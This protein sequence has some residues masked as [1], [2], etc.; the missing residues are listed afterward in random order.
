MGKFKPSYTI[1]ARHYDHVLDGVDYDEW[2]RFLRSAMIIHN[3]ESQNV[4]EI[5]T[6]TGKFGPR[7]ASDGFDIVGIDNSIAMLKAAKRRAR[8]RYHIVCADARSFSF[9]KKFDFIFCV[10][11]TLN[12][13]TSL[14]DVSKV[15]TCARNALSDSGV[16]LFDTTTEF[17]IIEHFDGQKNDYY[18]QGTYIS[19]S[20][21][22]DT[23]TR[24]VT[25]ILKFTA[26]E[27]TVIEKHIQR[28]HS[29]REILRA[30][31]KAGLELIAIYG[32]SSFSPPDEST[33]MMNFLVKRAKPGLLQRFLKLIRLI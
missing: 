10:H 33:I 5:G 24:E 13:I 27:K 25:S 15:L 7:F 21:T 31:R 19:W 3:P 11:D 28:I 4:L 18:H 6:G 8:G 14:E 2:Y 12:Y 26:S 1:F 32:D 30:I 29:E 17:N 22:Y 16:F 23:I 20:N 9:K